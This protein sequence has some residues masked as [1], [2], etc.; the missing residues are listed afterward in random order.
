MELGYVV[1][2]LRYIIFVW[3]DTHSWWWFIVYGHYIPENQIKF[4][5]KPLL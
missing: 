5:G 2:D 4:I 1:T 3:H